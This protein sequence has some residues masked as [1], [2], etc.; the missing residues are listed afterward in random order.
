MGFGFGMIFPPSSAAALSCVARER[1]GYAASLYNMMRNTGAA[2]GIAWMTNML[3]RR[4]Q[5]HQARLV[6]HFSVF[7]AW[8][9]TSA[10]KHLPGSPGFGF[11]GQIITGQK[12]GFGMIYAFI[13]AQAAMLSF[14]D[15]Y[16]II[17]MMAF[18]MIPSFLFLRGAKSS[19]GAGH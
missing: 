4:Q 12:Q 14:N 8:K 9:I 7:E 1:M 2:V 13:Q 6:E 19:G 16:R 5:T 11:M 3:V 18:I 10:G 15:I 17:A